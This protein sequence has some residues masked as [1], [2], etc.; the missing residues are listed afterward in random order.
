[1]IKGEYKLCFHHSYVGVGWLVGFINVALELRYGL[2]ATVWE[3][4]LR[5]IRRH[6]ITI[7]ILHGG[8]GSPALV[9]R[10]PESEVEHLTVQHSLTRTRRRHT[11]GPFADQSRGVT[12]PSTD[13]GQCCFTFGVLLGTELSDWSTPGP[14]TLEEYVSESVRKKAHGR[15]KKVE[16]IYVQSC[17]PREK[18]KQEMFDNFKGEKGRF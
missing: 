13:Q 2:L 6:A 10:R 8:D 15:T 9:A 14:E 18:R 7:W 3:T 12:L 5:V 11:L 4:L 17:Q 1:M 16:P